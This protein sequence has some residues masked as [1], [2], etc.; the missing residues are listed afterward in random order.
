MAIKVAIE[1]RVD[2]AVAAVKKLQTSLRSTRQS[3]IDLEK[4]SA[5]GKLAN[6][7]ITAKQRAL[8]IDR[9]KVKRDKLTETM[10]RQKRAADELRKAKERES[11]QM[12]R[13]QKSLADTREKYLDLRD[14]IKGVGAET[15]LLGKTTTSF[16]ALERKLNSGALSA[17]EYQAAMIRYNRVARASQRDVKK[18]AEEQRRVNRAAGR[19]KEGFESLNKGM[20]ELTKSVQ[21]ALGPLSGV[22]ARITAF[23]ALLNT[24]SVIS[25]IAAASIIGISVATFKSIKAFAQMEKQQLRI[26][27]LLTATGNAAGTSAAEIQDF[28][29]RLGEDTLTSASKVRDAAGALLSFRSIVGDSFKQTLELAQDMASV[30]GGDLRTSTVQLAKALEDPIQGLTA[31]RRIG[32]TFTTEQRTLAKEMVKTGRTAEAQ[33]VIFDALESQIGGSARKEGQG[34]AG[35]VDTLSDRWRELM[36]RFGELFPIKSAIDA[37]SGLVKGLDEYIDSLDNVFIEQ[38]RLQAAQ[39]SLGASSPDFLPGFHRKQEDA[40]LKRLQRLMLKG[41]PASMADEAQFLFKRQVE[42][43]SK[44]VSEELLK[45]EEA[46]ERQIAGFHKS[47]LAVLKAKL[48]LKGYFKTAD[49]EIQ[50]FVANLLKMQKTIDQFGLKRDRTQLEA[51]K[52]ISKNMGVSKGG[53]IPTDPTDAAGIEKFG[54]QVIEAFKLSKQRSS[55]FEEELRLIRERDSVQDAINKKT[56]QEQHAREAINKLRGDELDIISSIDEL[57]FAGGGDPDSIRRQA[58]RAKIRALAEKTRFGIVSQ[59]TE[60]MDALGSIGALPKDTAKASIRLKE[61]TEELR[62]QSEIVK[63]LFVSNKLSTDELKVQSEVEKERLK[64]VE[65]LSDNVEQLTSEYE[66]QLRLNTALNTAFKVQAKAIEKLW[67]GVSDGIQNALKDSFRSALDEGEFSFRSF[68]EKILSLMKDL[69]AELAAALIFKPVIGGILGGLGAPA[70]VAGSGGG[71]LGGIGSSIA[72]SLI[73][74]GAKS[75]IG[76]SGVGTALF[77]S[78]LTSGGAASLGI[79]Q[80]AVGATSSG[81]LG[82]GGLGLGAAGGPLAI[83]A[84]AAAALLGGSLLGSG[85]KVPRAGARIGFGENGAFVSASGATGGGNIALV[86]AETK[87]VVDSLNEILRLN[88]G[89]TLSSDGVDFVGTTRSENG[90]ITRG[91]GAL[92]NDILS[93]GALRGVSQEAIDEFLNTGSFD[94]FSEAL[95]EITDTLGEFGDLFR[96][97]LNL[98]STAARRFAN[99]AQSLAAANDNLLVDPNLSPLS[100]ADRLAEARSQFTSLAESAQRGDIESLEQLEAAGSTLLEASRAFFASSAGFQSDFSFVRESLSVAAGQANLLSD[101]AAVQTALLQRQNTL[102]TEIN[103]NLTRSE[104]PNADLLKTQISEL[105]LN[106]G[107]LDGIG[108]VLEGVRTATDE[109]AAAQAVRDQLS[110]VETATGINKQTAQI[111]ANLLTGVT[112]MIQASTSELGALISNDNKNFSELIA[113]LTGRAGA[114][115]EKANPASGGRYTLLTSPMDIPTSGNTYAVGTGPRP[116]SGPGIYTAFA[117]GGIVTRPTLGLVGEGAGH[118]EAIIPLDARK[119]KVYDE[120]SVEEISSLRRQVAV[121]TDKLN[122]LIEVTRE[123]DKTSSI[124]PI[125]ISGRGR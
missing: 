22:A 59:S 74:E 116:T 91:A 2:S 101:T 17:K 123:S 78:T 12:L 45:I 73:G 104:G 66:K 35:A 10:K 16:N 69:A 41:G 4:E 70:S 87:K 51:L 99:V 18:L 49:E 9:E 32:V 11:A 84:L 33:A 25:A 82:A 125:I 95:E 75:A 14:S 90:Q 67:K 61:R 23:S 72:Q 30:F 58:G 37:L 68:A 42:A 124:N 39:R 100:P 106:K 94:A 112:A 83:A 44:G 5:K 85:T 98:A 96:D 97:N 76:A 114:L 88:P 92:L 20:T 1:V 81:I 77:G 19:G 60:D 27:G 86:V 113:A 63:S 24:A 108:T 55:S 119:I 120:K 105:E 26:Q 121:L 64:L 40:N 102:I 15:T 71:V 6:L 21:I 28:A 34:V 7:R 118:G 79:G 62:A 122:E 57:Q 80:A 93:S 117:E 107:L 50:N 89:A 47:G 110:V 103:E 3:I 54:K 52:A 46:L 115:A 43:G 111:N 8:D 29:R 56:T 48:E 109:A 31:L 38:K 36:E 13:Q 65:G 53:I